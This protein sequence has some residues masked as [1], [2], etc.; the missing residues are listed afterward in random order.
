MKLYFTLFFSLFPISMRG[1]D[2]PQNT[3]KVVLK[4]EHDVPHSHKFSPAGN[5]IALHIKQD[6]FQDVLRIYDTQSG[7]FHREI[8]AGTLTGYKWSP[9]GSYVLVR[10]AESAHV[11]DAADAQQICTIPKPQWVHV[12][13]SADEQHIFTGDKFNKDCIN[14]LNVRG[15][16]RAQLSSGR[17]GPVDPL[18]EHISSIDGKTY[19]FSA[20]NFK[21]K[22]KIPSRLTCYSNDG[23]LM[24]AYTWNQ[25]GGEHT[26]FN[27]AFECIRRFTLDKRMGPFAYIYH[28]NA[29]LIAY[30]HDRETRF[31]IDNTNK[32]PIHITHESGS[33][34]KSFFSLDGKYR[35]VFKDSKDDCTRVQVTD[36]E[37]VK[38][39]QSKKFLLPDIIRTILYTTNP[40]VVFIGNCYLLDLATCKLIRTYMYKKKHDLFTKK[41]KSIISNN[42]AYLDVESRNGD[43]EVGIIQLD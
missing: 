28:L 31:A 26:L 22:G 30:Y 8:P 33:Q 19:F 3:K 29:L 7:E 24:G 1:M 9:Q 35:I 38:S 40:S 41:T 20:A 42:G 13:F 43:T 36:A 15:V 27:R 32:V 17:I 6:G 11:Y 34:T 23:L 16:Q 25:E 10:T 37:D 21:K 12:R 5:R 4:D 2:A 14:V 39:E 18:N